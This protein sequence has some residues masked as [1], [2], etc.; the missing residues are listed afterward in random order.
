M[1]KAE[2]DLQRELVAACEKALARLLQLDAEDE[3]E[4]LGPCP[5]CEAIRTVLKKVQERSEP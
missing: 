4:E 5:A 2:A 3:L 1:N